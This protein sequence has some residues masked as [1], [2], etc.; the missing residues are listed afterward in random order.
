MIKRDASVIEYF[1]RFAIWMLDARAGTATP[2]RRALVLEAIFLGSR[3]LFIVG[4]NIAKRC[5]ML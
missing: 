2:S 4:G 5:N 3:D 1:V